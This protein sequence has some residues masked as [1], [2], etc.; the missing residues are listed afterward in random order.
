M[1]MRMEPGRHLPLLMLLLLTTG[2]CA[3]AQEAESG[4]ADADASA[5]TEEADGGATP[6]EELTEFTAV[7]PFPS[8]AGWFPLFVAEDK[9]FFAEEGMTVHTEAVDSS[10]GVIQALVSGQAEFGLPSPGPLVNAVEE[11][12]DLLSVYLL[13]QQNPFSV[14]VREDSDIETLADLRGMRVGIPDLGSGQSAFIQALLVDS[15]D[16]SEEDYDLVTIGDGGNAVVGFERD[17]IDAYVASTSVT[18]IMQ[19]RGME[20]R[21]IVPA[22]YRSFFDAS[23]V[24]ERSF[25]DENLEF[26]EGFGR[27]MAKATVWGLANP[28]GVLEITGRYFPEEV[29]DP[30]LARLSLAARE[31]VFTPEHGLWGH[32]DEESAQRYVEFLIAQ[33]DIPADADASVFVN[34][35]VEAYNEFDEEMVRNLD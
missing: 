13:Y 9:G 12:E 25:R 20:I 28:D 23:V 34:D 18:A 11:G 26:V 15:E 21:N 33:G 6:E 16:M 4:S 22:D 3:G 24:V 27:A 5:P 8:G 29:E 35:H 14:Q 7:I 30:E 32:T 19:H 2:A 17:E 10:G 1:R 31:E